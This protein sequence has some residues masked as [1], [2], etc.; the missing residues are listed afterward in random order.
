MGWWSGAW[1]Q[2]V[3]EARTALERA[4]PV[5]AQLEERAGGSRLA[6]RG[7]RR[8]RRVWE[9]ENSRRERLHEEDIAQEKC[10]HYCFIFISLFSFFIIFSYSFLFKW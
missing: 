10:Q 4:T 8:E 9:R 3:A 2:A 1:G 6:G 7:G 5:A